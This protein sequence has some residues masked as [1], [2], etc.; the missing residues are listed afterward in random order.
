VNA[1]DK[2]RQGQSVWIHEMV[3]TYCELMSTPLGRVPVPGTLDLLRQKV[4][5]AEARGL[6]LDGT[7][8]L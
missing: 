2:L 4:S 6:L 7:E 1:E 8:G 5:E 3:E